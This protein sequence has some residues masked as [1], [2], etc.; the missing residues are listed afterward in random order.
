VTGD[1]VYAAAREKTEAWLETLADRPSSP[2]AA[3]GWRYEPAEFQRALAYKALMAA[4][5]RA[6]AARKAEAAESVSVADIDTA[7]E[8]R[9]MWALQEARNRQAGV[10]LDHDGLPQV[11]VLPG[12]DGVPVLVRTR[13][14]AVASAVTITP[15]NADVIEEQLARRQRDADDRL[16][17]SEFGARECLAAGI[18]TPEAAAAYA[19][20]F[21][22]APGAGPSLP[23]G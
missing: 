19:D 15:R 2:A 4:D 8:E 9:R 22:H 23:P 3:D 18:V 11:T 6:E 21:G 10:R 16:L 7:A 20:P 14:P 13:G 1:V 17:L 5:A 12:S